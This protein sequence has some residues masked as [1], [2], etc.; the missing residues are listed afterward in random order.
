[1]ARNFRS[2]TLATTIY[3]LYINPPCF[4]FICI[5]IIDKNDNEKDQLKITSEW[6]DKSA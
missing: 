6:S 1:M 4:L 2:R 5:F 3:A